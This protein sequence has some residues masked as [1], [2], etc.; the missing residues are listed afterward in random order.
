MAYQIAQL[1]VTL[2][3]AEGNFCCFKTL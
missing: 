1:P 3:E 2:S